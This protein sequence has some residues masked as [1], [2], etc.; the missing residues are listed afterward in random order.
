MEVY[1]L[2]W[3]HYEDSQVEGIFLSVET[4]MRHLA[5]IEKKL[6]KVDV[7]EYTDERVVRDF[8]CPGGGGYTIQKFTIDPDA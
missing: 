2:E 3:A 1:V 5:C 6:T 8:S 7:G 4:A